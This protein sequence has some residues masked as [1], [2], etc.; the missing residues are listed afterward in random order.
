VA[1]VEADERPVGGELMR[2]KGTL[3]VIADGERHL[4]GGRPF[5]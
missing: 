1:V 2:L 3:Q 5:G 4:D